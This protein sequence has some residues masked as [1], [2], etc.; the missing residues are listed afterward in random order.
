MNKQKLEKIILIIILA[1]AMFYLYFIYLFQPEWNVIKNITQQINTQT[2][3]LNRLVAYNDPVKLQQDLVKEQEL[4]KQLSSRLPTTLDKPQISVELYLLAKQQGVIPQSVTFEPLQNKG[5]HQEL[6]ITFVG[7]GS[8]ANILSMLG[9]LER[10]PAAK[11]ALKSLNLT[12]G[13][14]Q[15]TANIK[16]TSFSGQLQGSK[17]GELPDFMKGSFGVDNPANLFAPTTQ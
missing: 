6:D 15:T 2:T 7:Q 14:D 3:Y 8:A 1:A 11:Y 5:N 17:S 9:V 4:G 12:T 13:K 16:L 10:G